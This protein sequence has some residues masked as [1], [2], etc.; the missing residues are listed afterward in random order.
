[1]AKKTPKATVK[2]TQA[3]KPPKTRIAKAPAKCAKAN[4]AT[5]K[6]SALDAAARFLA[7]PASR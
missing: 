6:I 4:A 2:A 1:M 5:R 7:R 3:T